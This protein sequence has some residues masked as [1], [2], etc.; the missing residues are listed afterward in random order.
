MKT[1]RFKFSGIDH[2]PLNDEETVRGQVVDIKNQVR[3][4]KRP[5]AASH[6]VT[7][8][9]DWLVHDRFHLAMSLLTVIGKKVIYR[10]PLVLVEKSTLIPYFENLLS[11]EDMRP[12]YVWPQT[13][14]LPYVIAT[15]DEPEF[16]LYAFEPGSAGSDGLP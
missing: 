15:N 13:E 1:N 16:F 2:L 11:Q 14:G 8:L 12:F 9:A 10:G 4:S 5:S 6:D 7:V 3:L